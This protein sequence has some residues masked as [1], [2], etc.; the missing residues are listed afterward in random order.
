M[1]AMRATDGPL[2]G[3]YRV[4]RSQFLRRCA[5]ERAEC[6]FGDGP[7]E[8]DLKHGD[9][10][11][12]TVHHSIPVVL[13]PDLEMEISLWRPAHDRCNKLGEAAFGDGCAAG[14]MP[15]WENDGYGVASEDWNTV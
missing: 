15:G 11:A 7:I 8:Y 1:K 2:R 13:R 6:F 9:P 5:A 12:P 14:G 3:A 10:R 4:L